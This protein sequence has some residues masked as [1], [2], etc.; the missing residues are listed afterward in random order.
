MATLNVPPLPPSPRDDAIQLYAAFKGFGCDT[1]V[2]INILAHRDATQRA[3]IQQEYKAM[4]SGDLLKRLSSEL[5]GKLETALLLWM[6]DPAGRDAIILRQSLTLPKNLEAAT[7]LICSRTPS[8]LHYLRQIYHSKFG[9]Y[10]EHD[11]ETNTSG[12]HKKILLAYVTTPRHEGPEVNREMAE[13]DAKVLYKAGEKR[14]GTDEK[15]F[16]Q[17]FSERSAAHLA[18]ITSYYHSM[19]GHSLKKAVKKETSGNFALALLTIVQCAENP[20]KYFAKV[21]R[22]AMKGLGTDDTKLIRVIVTRA[23]I[24]LQYIKAEYLKKYKKTL[25]DA[26]HSETSG[27]YRAFLLSLLGPNQ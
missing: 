4:Y 20:A 19:Y 3:Y 6:H 22:K 2:V 27:H 21:L 13:K 1:S 18:A 8:Q 23:E 7:Q 26:V 9:V 12:D 16:V 5:S 25:N 24:D 11:I 17:I 15:T 10:L 14:L